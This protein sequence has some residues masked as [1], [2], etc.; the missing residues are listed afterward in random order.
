MDRTAATLV[1]FAAG[2]ENLERRAAA[3]L[4]LA[5]L[6]LADAK[7]I[8]VVTQ[9]L[10]SDTVL[11]EYALRYVEKLRPAAAVAGVL[12]LLAAADS[13]VR[14]R[15]RRL[16]VAYGA[17]A[18]APLLRAAKGAARPWLLGAVE[19][20]ATL[21]TAPAIDAVVTIL[22]QADGEIA[23]AASDALHRRIRELEPAARAAVL[24]HLLGAADRK[25]VDTSGAARLFLVRACGALALPEARRWLLVASTRPD[26]P[27]VR[28]EALAALATC[29]LREKLLAKEVTALVAM[30][31]EPGSSHVAR[32]ALTLLEGHRFGAEAQ[33][34]LLR[35]RQSPHAAVRS[36][37]LAKLAES[38]APAAVK[39]LLG[40]LD[41]AESVRRSAAGS[42]R[43][44]P[45]ARQALMKRFATATDASTAF[46]MAETLAGY[47]L[48][49]RRPVL[50]P[51]W[52]RYQHAFAADD[53]IQGAFLHFLRTAAPEFLA[54]SLRKES[55]RLIKAGRARDAV[56][57]RQILRDL[58]VAT[59]DDAYDLALAHVKTRR[60]GLDAP[61][62]RPDAA[63][64]LLATLEERRFPTATRLKRERTL[65]P[66]ELYAIGFALAETSGAGRRL[67][68]EILAYL[69]ARQPRTKL[70]KSARNKLALTG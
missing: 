51:L 48:P 17:P 52:R 36:F 59:D 22:T 30:L 31:D 66:E 40:S 44:I 65:D 24:R 60:R 70:G 34:L 12:P 68:E 5:E 18:V 21:A 37:A 58:P 6:K 69:A 63:L 56:R 20:L 13:G 45:E 39:A 46:T 1:A 10:A 29:V 3:M 14:E 53:R 35:L 57:L 62:R 61:F 27:H 67:G 55:S 25:D 47:G 41:D 49:W 42:L 43:K 4:L 19:V 50:D 28:T 54:E 8:A 9:A 32:Q 33:S 2:P 7:T 15:A 11:Q 64:D 26:Q 38:D 23:R 16:L